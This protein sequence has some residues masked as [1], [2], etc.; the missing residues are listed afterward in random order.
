[1]KSQKTNEKKLKQIRK[2]NLTDSANLRPVNLKRFGQNKPKSKRIISIS[3]DKDIGQYKPKSKKIFSISQDKYIGQNYTKNNTKNKKPRNLSMDRN[4]SGNQSGIKSPKNYK[5]YIP[6]SKRNKNKAKEE[7]ETKVDPL[8]E[9]YDPNLYGFNLYKNIKENLSNKDRLCK[10]KLTKDSLYCLDCKISTCNKCP[11]FHV[12]NGHNLVPKYLYYDSDSP[13][14]IDTFNEIENLLYTENPVYLDNQMLKEELKKEVTD[15]INHLTKRLNEIKNKKLKELDKLFEE[16]DDCMKTLKEREAKIKQEI[17]D[18]LEK[19]KQKDFYFIKVQEQLENENNSPDYDVL[20]NLKKDENGDNGLIQINNDT[21]NTTFLLSY[22]LF[23]NTHFINGQIIKFINDIKEN[24]ERYLREFNEIIQLIREDIEKLN[25]PFNGKFNYGYLT[26]DFYKMVQDKINKYIEKIDAMKKYIYDMVNKDGNYDAIEKDVRVSET[27]IK[28]KLDNIINDQYNDKDD[29]TSKSGKGKN[30]QYHRLS[31][32]MNENLSA[33]KLKNTLKR[34]SSGSSGSQDKK[35]KFRESKIQNIYNSQDDVRL[36]KDILQKYFA[37]ETYNTIHNYFR[38]KKPK[39]DDDAIIEEL[40]DDI[41]D[42]VKPLA[43]TNEIQLF[44]KENTILTRIKVDFDRKK[45]K[46]LTFLNGCRSVLKKDMLYIFGGVDQE[47][48]PTKIAYVYDIKANELRVMPEMLKP[49][50][51]HSVAYLDYYK[52]I[53]VLGGE[54]TGTCEVFDLNT[55]KWRELPDMNIPRAHCNIYLDRLTNVIYAFFGVVGNI[56]EKHNYTD[57]IECLELQRLALGWSVIDYE[58]RA[59]M[60]FKS[61]YNKILPL[62]NEMILIYGATNMR[63]FIKKAAIYLVPRF[64]IVKIDKRIF[65]KIK[66]NSIH[67]RIL[68]KILSSYI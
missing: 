17:K 50:A 49:H 53:L 41:T 15:N 19:E 40:F 9:N 56:T 20:T 48:K 58:N 65:R 6:G 22:D 68:S 61:G 27:Q 55:G 4:I 60:D 21:F 57:V 33:S 59:E 5:P 35:E 47:N 23:K 31:M 14:F 3:Q 2:D 64:E 30:G 46:Y 67:S 63:D 7:E 45:H 37:Y 43:G 12:H 25:K 24:K 8:V 29:A 66:E 32:Y 62:T 10:D 36:D 38:Y 26:T 39:S 1:M 42:V 54:N 52:S 16:T 13:V 28:Q 18:Y 44:D 11:L 34:L 51:Y